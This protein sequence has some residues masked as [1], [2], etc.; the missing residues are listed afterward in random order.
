ML[1]IGKHC[2]AF[3]P[4]LFHDLRSKQLCILFFCWDNLHKSWINTTARCTMCRLTGISAVFFPLATEKTFNSFEIYFIS[5]LFLPF[6]TRSFFYKR[7]I[8]ECIHYYFSNKLLV[9][10]YLPTTG[11]ADYHPTGQ[12]R[13]IQ[14]KP[15]TQY[16]C[17]VAKLSLHCANLLDLTKRQNQQMR[18]RVHEKYFFDGAVCYVI[19]RHLWNYRRH[20]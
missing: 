9:H 6:F 14:E 20:R 13:F 15:T 5:Y 2:F 1:L 3:F 12:Y 17:V 19:C 10:T 4:A 16:S 11:Y 7:V 18:D 8:D